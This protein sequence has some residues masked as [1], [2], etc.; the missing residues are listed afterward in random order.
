L[1]LSSSELELKSTSSESDLCFETA[2]PPLQPPLPQTPPRHKSCARE[3][4]SCTSP[5]D[6]LGAGRVNESRSP[7]LPKLIEAAE[8]GNAHVSD[9][10]HKTGARH[11]HEAEGRRHPTH[12][13][14]HGTHAHPH[15]PRRSQRHGAWS[16]QAST[17]MPTWRCLH[18]HR[19][20]CSGLSCATAARGDH[21]RGT[22]SGRWVKSTDSSRTRNSSGTLRGLCLRRSTAV[23]AAG[24]WTA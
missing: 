9:I 11:E 20:T 14:T 15:G 7:R 10:C 6:V 4:A 2:S 1:P 21:H 17:P 18:H 19:G 23:A 24:T 5:P 8:V 16:A 3:T 22:R 13:D 12:R